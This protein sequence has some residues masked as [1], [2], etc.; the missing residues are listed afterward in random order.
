[1]HRCLPCVLAVHYVSSCLSKIR[2]APLESV[3]RW[4]PPEPSVW[5]R[6]E[7][8][9]FQE[10]PRPFQTSRRPLI[11]RCLL[12]VHAGRFVASALSKIRRAPLVLVLRWPP[13]GPSEWQRSEQRFFQE[14]PTTFRT[15]RRPL[16][17]R[18]LPFVLVVR[19]V[20]FAQSK[21]LCAP[22][23]LVL[24]WPPPELLIW[25][26]LVRRFFQ[27]EPMSYL[28]RPQLVGCWLPEESS[29]ASP[30]LNAAAPKIWPISDKLLSAQNQ[31]YFTSL[32][33]C[34]SSGLGYST[35]STR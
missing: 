3:L 14:S 10:S 23:A 5:Q 24:R 15:S 9:F 33:A 17:H 20:A 4:P 8:H 29:D 21:I 26:R 22:P 1:M 11:Y 6:L 12:F 19:F 34:N 30:C 32:E 35:S 16:M 18:C 25:Q 2:R 7:Q 31:R 28:P 13:P 27:Q